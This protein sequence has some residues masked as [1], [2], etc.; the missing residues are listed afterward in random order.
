VSEQRR[1]RL[2]AL[3]RSMTPS[4]IR[5]E[6][7]PVV[8]RPVDIAP[9]PGSVRAR[10]PDPTG[11]SAG[12]PG[13]QE[14]DHGQDAAMVILRRLERQLSEDA[15]HVLLDRSLRDPQLPGDAGV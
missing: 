3:T 12:L 6:R 7:G 1:L 5:E 15:V 11:R 13:L 2:G 8:G 14:R 4:M 10:R 9:S